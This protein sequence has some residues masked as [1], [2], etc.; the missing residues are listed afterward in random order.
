MDFEW[1][2]AK[3]LANIEKH[4]ID[5]IDAVVLFNN[6]YLTAPAKTVND[7][8]RWLATGVIEK[9][10]VT[11]IFARRGPVVRIIS[12]RRARDDERQKYQKIFSG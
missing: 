9:T 10:Y 3:R 11:G 5:F 1:D 7:E 4:G 2:E 8:K 6:P 12:M